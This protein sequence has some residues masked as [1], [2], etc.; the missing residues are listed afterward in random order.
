MAKQLI[1]TP[2]AVDLT[3]SEYKDESSPFTNAIGKGSDNEGDYAEWGLVTGSQAY[4]KVYWSFDMSSIPSN[5]TITNVTCSARC[6]NT[7]E[8]IMQGGNTL[9][10]IGTVINGNEWTNKTASDNAAF[11]KTATVVTVSDATFTRAELDNFRL[12]IQAVRGFLGTGTSYHTKFYG[13]TLTIDYI[14]NY[15]VTFKDWNG[16]VIQTVTV[17][18]GSDATLPSNNPTRDGYRFIGWSDT[19]INVTSDTDV[20]AQ[21]IKTYNIVASTNTGGSVSPSGTT[22]LDEGQSQT[23]TISADT[24]YRIK[25]VTVDGADQGAITTYT[26]SNVTS[27]HTIAVEFEVIP[28]YTIT[29]S[30]N[31][32]GSIIPSGAITVLEGGSQ[33]YTISVK[34][35]YRLSD[36]KVDNVSQG[37]ISTYT[38]SNVTAN[39]TIQAIFEQKPTYTIIASA[40]TGGTISPNGSIN[41]YEGGSQ[42]YTIS[43]NIGY[44]I[45]D[46]LVDGVS[47]GAITSYIFSNV[48]NDHTIE[49]V[50]EPVPTVVAAI[51]KNVFYAINLFEGYD[52]FSIGKDGVY[53][54][55]IHEDLNENENIYLDSNCILHVFKFIE[56]NF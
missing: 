47:Q 51:E 41:V 40:G 36:V 35:G 34:S 37:V 10:A 13:A 24:G 52:N 15:T 17:V 5:A 26:F 30:A 7:N 45:K 48:N 14:E 18:E 42:V 55:A 11:G 33:V 8:N 3:A 49:V 31:A 2:A 27:D 32:G 19:Y 44:G 38:F 9:I 16:D 46:V 21:Y 1:C 50:F 29:S 12:K 22:T 53:L 28:T 25:S 54:N 6:S 23:Y 43:A 39:H 20:I 56:G 4:T